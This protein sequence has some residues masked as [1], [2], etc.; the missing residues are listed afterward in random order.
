MDN[1]WRYPDIRVIYP[2]NA[3]E[4]VIAGI[5]R[6]EQKDIDRLD[7]MRITDLCHKHKIIKS[8]RFRE[9]IDKVRELRNRMHIGGLSELE[10][11]YSKNDLE[12][13][14]KIAKNVKDLAAK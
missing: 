8:K 11:E 10:K 1:E 4:E 3:S 9:G 13:C 5:R 7:F 6:K 2:I 14:F 12:F